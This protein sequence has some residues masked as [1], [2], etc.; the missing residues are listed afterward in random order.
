MLT[1]CQNGLSLIINCHC[2]AGCTVTWLAITYRDTATLMIGRPGPYMTCDAPW[3]GHGIHIFHSW[4][5][6][7]R[8]VAGCFSFTSESGGSHG[9]EW[10][11]MTRR[12]LYHMMRHVLYG[13][14]HCDMTCMWDLWEMWV[15]WVHR[16]RARYVA[17]IRD[18]K[19]IWVLYG[20]YT[21]F[22][23]DAQNHTEPW[24]CVCR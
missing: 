2:V 24:F 8:C 1:E 18:S 13:T 14:I 20:F 12:I 21:V 19:V 11:N 5:K 16:H 10:Q 9:V 23:S 3:P 4:D 7:W 22:L 17:C 15:L 6:G